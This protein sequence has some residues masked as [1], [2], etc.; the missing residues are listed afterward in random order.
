MLSLGKETPVRFYDEHGAVVRVLIIGRLEHGVIKAFRDW[1]AEQVGDPY[2]EAE[3]FI[4]KVSPE[5]GKRMLAEARAKQDQLESFSLESPL[6]RRFLSTEMGMTKLLHLLLLL[7]QPDA[8]SADAFAVLTE[9]GSDG[10]QKALE[11]GAG[12]IPKNAPQ[13]LPS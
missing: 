10:T 11:N 9:L 13:V 1:V 2:K 6:A 4:D 12:T 8:T 3:R 7:K 5:E